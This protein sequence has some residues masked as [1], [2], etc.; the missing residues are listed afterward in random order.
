MPTVR[1]NQRRTEARRVSWTSATSVRDG[2]LTVIN[3]CAD[4]SKVGSALQKNFKAIFP[5]E[6]ASNEAVTQ[7]ILQTLH[8]DKSLGCGQG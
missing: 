2:A 3:A 8:G 6:D 5:S 7:A 1:R 4:S